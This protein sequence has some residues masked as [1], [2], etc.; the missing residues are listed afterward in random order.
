[1]SCFVFN[2]ESNNFKYLFLSL[3]LAPGDTHFTYEGPEGQREK[4]L[5]HAILDKS[6]TKNRLL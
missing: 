6:S 3:A 5:I 4:G 1:M 2:L